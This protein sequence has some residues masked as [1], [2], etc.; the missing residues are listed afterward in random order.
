MMTD[1]EREKLTQAILD[2]LKDLGWEADGAG[3]Y[4]LEPEDVAELIDEMLH[5]QSL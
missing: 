5:N 3:R 4:Y 1:H 2:T